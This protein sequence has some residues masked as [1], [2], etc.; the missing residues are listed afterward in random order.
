MLFS[1]CWFY[2]YFIIFVFCFA[3]LASKQWC[4]CHLFCWI[5]DRKRWSCPWIAYISI[6]FR[7]LYQTTKFQCKIWIFSLISCG[8]STLAGSI[9]VLFARVVQNRFFCKVLHLLFCQASWIIK[10]Y[11]RTRNIWERPSVKIWIEKNKIV[12][13]IR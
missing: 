2:F 3:C 1:Q 13:P 6:K 8:A 5:C 12:L 10:S 7:K 4:S 11:A 9:M